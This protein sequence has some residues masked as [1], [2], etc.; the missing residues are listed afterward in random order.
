M[1]HRL[2]FVL[3]D[4][5]SNLLTGALVGWLSWLITDPGWNMF[6]AMILMMILGMIVAIVLWLPVSVFF[7]AM[8][9]MVPMMLTGMISG[10]VV[11]M[12]L[13]REALAASSCLYIGGVCGILSIVMIWI[14]NSARRGTQPL[15]WR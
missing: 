3:G 2:Y 12:W 11:A 13:T 9:A 4:L 8:E 10:M 5:F 6:A 15:R 14:L 1:D 7:G